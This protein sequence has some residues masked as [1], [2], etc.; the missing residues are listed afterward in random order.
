MKIK[1][2]SMYDD[3]VFYGL[4]F[5][6]LN[7]KSHYCCYLKQ[8]YNISQARSRNSASTHSIYYVYVVDLVIID[9]HCS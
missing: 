7:R 4:D 3:I 5:F 8:I 6:N 1:F 2:V 9:Q